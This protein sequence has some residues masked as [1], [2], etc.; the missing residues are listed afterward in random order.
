MTKKNDDQNYAQNT[1]LQQTVDSHTVSIATIT[2]SLEYMSKDVV[3]IKDGVKGIIDK[4]ENGVVKK[5]E[6][7]IFKQRISEDI[8]EIKDELKN[9]K[10]GQT[11]FSRLSIGTIFTA[12]VSLITTIIGGI[13]LFS[14]T[15]R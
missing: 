2:Q 4:I 11:W 12:S 6:F 13:I 1:H 3:E 9:V 14:I 8:K 5:D 15:Q 7:E 10:E